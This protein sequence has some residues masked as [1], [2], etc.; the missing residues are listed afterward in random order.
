M[1]LHRARD[2]AARNCIVMQ[3][4][5]VKIT[6]GSPGSIYTAWVT[7]IELLLHLQTSNWV[8]IF[9]AVSMLFKTMAH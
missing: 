5:S 2:V 8:D 3:N 1:S 6:G 9:I 4:L 7:L